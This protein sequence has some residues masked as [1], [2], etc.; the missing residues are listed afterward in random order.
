[1]AC[2]RTGR[3]YQLRDLNGHEVTP[4]Q[5]RAIITEHYTV[6]AET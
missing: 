4:T 3:P 1:M 5:A 2:W 6:S